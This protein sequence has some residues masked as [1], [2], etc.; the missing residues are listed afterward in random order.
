MNGQATATTLVDTLLL[1]T[2]VR[3]N[4]AVDLA[5]IVGFSWFVALC[6][7]ISFL[8]PGTAVPISGQ[9]FAVLLAAALLGSR[10]G[11]LS[12]MAYL[13]QGAMGLPVFA[14]TATM[15]YGGGAAR[16]A[17]PTGGYLIGFVAAAFVVGF[18][19]ERGWDR[20]FWTTAL[21]MLCGSAVIYLF[22]LPWLARFFAPAWLSGWQLDFK[23]LDPTN[24]VLLAGLYPFIPGDLIKLVLAAVALPSG[25]ALL[26]RLRG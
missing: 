20:R 8:I 9:T 19:A 4:L 13:A 17:G 14:F 7:R 26:S 22:G 12:M 18:L 15:G 16:F 11:T 10:R 25:W 21:A 5:L 23:Y 1:K 6:A 24:G 3:H 2:G